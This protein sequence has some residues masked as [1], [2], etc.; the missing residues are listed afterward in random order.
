MRFSIISPVYG[1]ASLLQEL[2]KEIEAAI[3][4]ITNDYEII[5]VEDHS[6]DNSKD[7]IRNICAQNQHVIGAF[8]SR[9]F[10]QQYAIHTGFTLATGD[11][12]VT[13][14]CDLQDTPALIK[15]LYNKSQEG[16][17]IVFA[18]RQN[19]QDG[20]IK[21][22]GS[23]VFNHVLG[24][25]TETVQDE[26][27]ANFVLYKKKA[28]D[29]M[30]DMGDYRR[31]YPLMNHWVGFDTC[32]L[33]IPH[34][35]RTDGKASSYSMRKRIELALNTAVAFSTKPLRLIIYS[36]A[37]LSIIAIIMALAI[38]V[39]YMCGTTI[40]SG[41]TTLFVSIWFVA[42]LMMM[43]MG[44]VAI[45]VGNVFEQ[46]KNRPITIVSEM[47]NKDIKK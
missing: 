31:Y 36:G 46:S 21:K 32:K 6:P 29:S 26:T 47:L 30:L 2:V 45:Y 24:F 25:L 8:H 9:N 23:K 11:Y 27:I 34:A 3:I 44:I 7:I 38:V 28:V 10:G 15:D 5:L 37:L 12:I 40:V 16:Y 43:T 1:A 18:S 17:D 19:R 41:W 22:L 35:E 20:Y 13:M 42:G 39:C 4:T 33:P 14:D